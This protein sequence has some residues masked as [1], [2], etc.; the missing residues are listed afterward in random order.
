MKSLTSLAKALIDARITQQEISPIVQTLIEG[1]AVQNEMIKLRQENKLG[2]HIGWKIGA[3]NPAA[4]KALGFGPFYGPLFEKN[5][6]N[7]TSV[8]KKSLGVAFKS[9]EAEVA[10][11]MAE[12]LPPLAGGREYTPEE[13]WQCV[14]YVMPSIELAASRIQTTLSPP[15]IVAD[16]AL[17]GCVVLGLQRYVCADIYQGMKGLENILVSLNVNGTQVGSARG[18]NV[19]GNPVVALTWLANQLNKTDNMLLRGQIV[20]TG[21]AVQHRDVNE[22]DS[23]EAVFQNMV[24]SPNDVN[25]FRADPDRVNIKVT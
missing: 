11:E 12:N 4:Q 6:E 25:Q 23:V 8:S 17:N 24:V 19:L 21:A 7:G 16:F 15:L 9:A 22:G 2:S 10:F 14:R 18:S 5:I 3:T 20:M 1:Y 13:V